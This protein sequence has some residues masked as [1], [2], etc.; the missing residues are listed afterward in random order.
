MRHGKKENHLGRS[1]V[2]RN[3]MMANMATSL[4]KHK[5]ITTTLAK[6]KALRG[7][8][9]PLLTKSKNDTTHSRRTVFSYLQD[10]EAVTELF[11]DVAEK[12]ANRPGG[13]T[14][15]IKLQNRLGDNAPMA[16]IELVDYNTVYNKEIPA[17][18][19]KST[20]RRG[21]VKRPSESAGNVAEWRKDNSM[22][23]PED[24]NATIR[25]IEGATQKDLGLL[26][27][28]TDNAANK[29]L[30]NT[31]ESMI[32][33]GEPKHVEGFAPVVEAYETFNLLTDYQRSGKIYP[34][35]SAYEKK[36]IKEFDEMDEAHR[37][38]YLDHL[39]QIF[40]DKT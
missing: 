18:A 14:R 2:H 19:R 3:A 23:S 9:E 38:S 20:R 26:S 16:M 29:L 30:D 10:K 17:T 33:R 8:V 34:R 36:L 24:P 11:R 4:I 32:L 31:Y 40:T 25:D 28:D 35:T 15:V 39:E 6:A 5:R 37:Q 1:D 27:Q 12:I 13:Y 7:Y 22:T 21:G